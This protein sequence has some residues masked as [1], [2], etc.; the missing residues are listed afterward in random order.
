MY[1]LA[2]IY[3]AFDSMLGNY[4]A[5]GKN[6]SEFENNRLKEEKIQRNEEKLKKFKGVLKITLMKIFMMNKRNHMLEILKI[7]NWILAY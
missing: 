1:S 6:V 5:L 7:R 3:A 4:R 2:S